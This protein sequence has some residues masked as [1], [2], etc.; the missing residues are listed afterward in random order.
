M[1][2]AQIGANHDEP[3]VPNIV[4]GGGGV[5]FIQFTVSF[6]GNLQK[7]C[8]RRETTNMKT[9]RVLSW[10]LA[11]TMVLSVC[12]AAVFADDTDVE[13][14][15]E[16]TNA[17]KAEPVVQEGTAT[18]GYTVWDP[19]P[20]CNHTST[21]ATAKYGTINGE[22]VFVVNRYSNS[23]KNPLITAKVKIGGVEYKTVIDRSDYTDGGFFEQGASTE[24]VKFETGVVFKDVTNFFY[25]S[26]SV[27]IID[28]ET[29][30]V[31]KLNIGKARS[32]YS[33]Y[34]PAEEQFADYT[35]GTDLPSSYTADRVILHGANYG[36]RNYKFHTADVP[37]KVTKNI[38]YGYTVVLDYND[39]TL[40]KKT[41]TMDNNK[42]ITI[43]TKTGYEFESWST[44]NYDL[45][46]TITLVANWKCAHPSY[47]EEVIKE[48][49]RE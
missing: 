4:N 44:T 32:Y 21:A 38:C 16:F 30:L 14:L 45:N 49:K 24:K 47:T 29:A 22:N 33:Y 18:E 9:K 46:N 25:S 43:P 15:T 40:G 39:E 10:L 27:S 28:V 7:F 23:M 42:F 34:N 20:N 37:N 26:S 1:L 11:L 2:C 5:V 36:V 41:V 12:S 19:N 31:S 6:R 13:N 17:V 8:K 48:P 3:K 35:E